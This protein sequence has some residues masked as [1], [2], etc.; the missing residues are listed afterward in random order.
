MYEPPFKRIKKQASQDQQ[1]QHQPQGGYTTS[2]E[3]K[4][5]ASRIES[6]RQLSEEMERISECIAD[7]ERDWKVRANA[8][9][10]LQE[11]VRSG[12]QRRFSAPSFAGL[13][14]TR[15][16][17]GLARQVV[18]TRSRVSVAASQCIVVLSAELREQLDPLVDTLVDACFAVLGTT[19]QVMRENANAAVL[20]L[21]RNCR[22]G[23]A[24]LG[25]ILDV[26]TTSKSHQ[27]RLPAV[28]Y[29]GA[30]LQRSRCYPGG[31]LERASAEIEAAVRSAILDSVQQVRASGMSLFWTLHSLWPEKAERIKATLT[32]KA[33]KY[34]MK[35]E[36]SLSTPATPVVRAT[37]AQTASPTFT[38]YKQ[39]QQFA[40]P[41]PLANAQRKLAQTPNPASL[42]SHS[43][44]STTATNT[45]STNSAKPTT[46]NFPLSSSVRGNSTGT[47]AVP[48]LSTS[49]PLLAS[50]TKA[51]STPGSASGPTTAS[52]ATPR[53]SQSMIA[54][55]ATTTTIN[56]P[57]DTRQKPPSSAKTT[58][59]TATSAV[60]A[61][62]VRPGSPSEL[63]PETRNRLAKAKCHGESSSSSSST[64]TSTAEE[65]RNV[66]FFSLLGHKDSAEERRESIVKIR[67]LV[68]QQDPKAAENIARIVTLMKSMLRDD[69]D[70]SSSNGE[71]SIFERDTLELVLTMFRCHWAHLTYSLDDLLPPVFSRLS[72]ES[73]HTD[74][75]EEIVGVV[76][77]NVNHEF[78]IP[79]VRRMILRTYNSGLASCYSLLVFLGKL[80]EKYPSYF[81]TL[82]H[83]RPFVSNLINIALT[84]TT[85]YAV[86]GVSCDALRALHS[87]AAQTFVAAFKALPEREYS[88]GRKLLAAAIPALDEE[89][90]AQTPDARAQLREEIIESI[91]TTARALCK[92]PGTPRRQLSPA[93]APQGQEC[94]N[95][96]KKPPG[97]QQQQQQETAAI[98]KDNV[99][100]EEEEEEEEESENYTLLPCTQRIVAFLDTATSKAY[101]KCPEGFSELSR[102]LK[103]GKELA[104]P[105]AQAIT[106]ALCR[107]TGAAQHPLMRNAGLLYLKSFIETYD[108]PA[109]ELG[110]AFAA[111]AGASSEYAGGLEKTSLLAGEVISVMEAVD[112]PSYFQALLAICSGEANGNGGKGAGITVASVDVTEAALHSMGNLFSHKAVQAF[113]ATHEDEFVAALARHLG[114]SEISIRRESVA[115]VGEFLCVMHSGRVSEK[116]QSALTPLQIKI[117]QHYVDRKKKI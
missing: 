72:A 46:T 111:A 86:K 83:L 41:A 9:D 55:A 25:R 105:D 11:V 88:D 36:H 70:S 22:V 23:R 81:T 31:M 39:Q 20:A 62:A 64:G 108:L 38:Y 56:T 115:C 82:A 16:R 3:A 58:A 94:E 40:T 44:L 66:N 37:P 45:V 112:S 75:C 43:S 78:L 92:P 74:V 65:L 15:V 101:A 19:N 69:G 49:N 95:K 33:K 7:T 80:V 93:K 61:T 17:D 14:Q 63:S 4:L 18:D 117:V 47:P 67:Q 77:D 53:P 99:E 87:A 50:S 26:I 24:G 68:E 103:S 79:A 52:T 97:Q 57:V 10:E 84:N 110:C 104:E 13:L 107:C 6:A 12:L 59:T 113:L 5:R 8:M 1:P 51:H 28:E 48:V 71:S 85:P 96:A 29:L 89:L 91:T 21:L 106:L 76:L 30:V 27:Q 114:S 98:G 109:S 35:N 100:E 90:S 60:S 116:V 73:P 102:V 54:V 2:N 34:L 32:S 42:T